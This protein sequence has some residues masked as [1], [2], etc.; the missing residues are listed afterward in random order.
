[1]HVGR[2]HPAASPMTDAA[3]RSSFDDRLSG[4]GVLDPSGLQALAIAP[5]AARPEAV[6]D[7]AARR[8]PFRPEV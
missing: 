7:P 5:G 4:T 6:T 1:M 3:R 2:E 8:G